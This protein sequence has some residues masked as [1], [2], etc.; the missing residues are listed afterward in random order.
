[1]RDYLKEYGI[2]PYINAHDTIT[3]YGASRVAQ[4]TK[5]AADQI[6]GCFVDIPE[7][8]RIL[9]ERIAELTHNEAAYIANCSS[10]A[11]QLCAAVCLAGGDDFAYKC[12]P[13]TL[14]RP[15]EIIILHSQHNCYDKALESA[16]AKIRIIGD[17][18]EVLEFD[19][20]ASITEKT[21]AVFY[22][23]ASIYR[24]GS[25]PLSRVAEIAHEKGVPVIVDAA[26]QLPPVENL[27]KFT[28]QGGDMVIFSGGKT[29]CGPQTSGLIVGKK[30]YIEDC[31][32]FGAPN[33][34]I[35][36]SSKASKESMIGLCV[37]IENY[38]NMDHTENGRR[39]SARVDEMILA[40]KECPL[41]QPYRVEHGSVGQSYPRAFAQIREPHTVSE[42]VLAMKEKHIF[43]GADAME[44]AIY[45]SPLNLTEEE[46]HIVCKALRE[47][48]EKL[49][50]QE[51]ERRA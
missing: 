7:L 2:Q 41:Y 36:R 49:S 9:G 39:L 1:M 20:K 31:R 8:Q 23:P 15:D 28:A 29:L 46:C 4:N 42:V 13:D 24:R 27:W 44:N 19:L 18:D 5:E 43:I 51:E 10:G 37:A 26:A 47:V 38:M 50:G 16:G 32:R 34:G 25:L 14:G 35:C 48:G 33:H 17:A 45:L 30:E 3:L 22:C 40:M 6:S 21:A 12:L 11:I